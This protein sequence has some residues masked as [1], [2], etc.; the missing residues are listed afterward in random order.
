MRGSQPR[1]QDL[2]VF[3]GLIEAGKLTSV[4]DRT[5]PLSQVPQAI[6]HLVEG[7][8]DGDKIVIRGRRL[9]RRV[10]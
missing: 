3:R 2:Q 9:V 7:Y 10:V 4:I 5:L 8:G 1:Q 6:R